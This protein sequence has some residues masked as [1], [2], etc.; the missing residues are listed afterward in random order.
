MIFLGLFIS[1]LSPAQ[2]DV[3]GWEVFA[4]V[5]FTEKFFSDLSEY[6]LVP[7]LDSRIRACEGKVMTLKGHYLP[8]DLEE[9]NVIVLSKYPYS[10]CFF[11]GGAGPESVAEIYFSSKRPRFKADQVITVKGRLVLNDRDIDH[12][13][14]MLKDAVLID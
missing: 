7:F 5:K 8:L 10:M 13:N 6:Y 4:R 2:T 14:F 12:M 1:I 11:C 9:P 3:K